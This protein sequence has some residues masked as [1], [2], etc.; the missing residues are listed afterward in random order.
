MKLSQ[1]LNAQEALGTLGHAQGLSSVVAYRISKNIKAI[2]LE[3]KE[4][5]EA[6]RKLCEEKT[7]KDEEGKPI[8]IDG[9]YDLTEEALKEVNNELEE[10][11]NEELD[12]TIKQLTLEEIDRAGLSAFQIDSI[13]FMIEDKEEMK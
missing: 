7:N 13:D 12:I 11:L 5:D 3:I 2:N 9:R 8:I 1:L 6:R 4:Y 10:L